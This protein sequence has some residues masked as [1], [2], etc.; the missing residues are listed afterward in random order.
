M[1]LYVPADPFDLYSN[2]PGG[3]GRSGLFYILLQQLLEQKQQQL[4]LLKISLLL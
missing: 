3:M 1:L 4:F 2:L